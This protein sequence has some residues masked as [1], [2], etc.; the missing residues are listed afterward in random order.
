[1]LW[2]AVFFFLAFCFL[3]VRVCNDAQFA[4]ASFVGSCLFYFIIGRSIAS[5]CVRVVR[6]TSTL[7]RDEKNKKKHAKMQFKAKEEEKTEV[8]LKRREKKKKT[9]T[10]T[11]I[12]R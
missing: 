12:H 10:T 4:I 1:M 11:Y 6:S 9:T 2:L 8:K 5:V 7:T 3:A